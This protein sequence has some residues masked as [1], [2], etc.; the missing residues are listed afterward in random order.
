MQSTCVDQ[1]ELM[2]TNLSPFQDKVR[3][4]AWLDANPIPPV[5]LSENG[6]ERIPGRV[7]FVMTLYFK[8]ERS[9]ERRLAMLEITKPFREWVGAENLGW[10]AGAY[11]QKMHFDKKKKLDLEQVKEKV[12]NPNNYFDIPMSS[13]DAGGDDLQEVEANAQRFYLKATASSDEF[14][15]GYLRA[16]VPMSWAI[17]Q[18]TEKSAAQFFFMCAQ[19]LQALHGDF[20]L[21]ICLPSRNPFQTSTLYGEPIAKLVRKLPGLI[22]KTA[23]G[24]QGA[25]GMG[26]IGWMTVVSNEWLAKIGGRDKILKTALPASVYI[27]EL[28]DGLVF[29]AGEDPQFEL[30]DPE[31]Y[32]AIAKLLRPLRLI[33]GESTYTNMVFKN[34]DGTASYIADSDWY[35]SRFD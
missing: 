15:T 10:W 16:H 27:T 32:Q 17:R 34:Q 12:L 9:L 31:P 8:K 26:P 4:A 11:T 29:Q 20:G 18:P 33:A 22:A 21:G 30:T 19:K 7:G 5:K 3:T 25:Q 1:I 13:V 28:P 2:M 6:K 24:M 23:N 14:H 35:L